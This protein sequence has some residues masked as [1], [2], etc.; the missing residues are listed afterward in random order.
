MDTM[1][2]LGLLES[3]FVE[4]LAQKWNEVVSSNVVGDFSKVLDVVQS[5]AKELMLEETVRDKIVALIPFFIIVEKEE[6]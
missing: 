2:F 3:Q 4:I 6:E 1:F 5:R